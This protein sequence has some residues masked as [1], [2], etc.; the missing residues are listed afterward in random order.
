MRKLNLFLIVATLLLSSC[1]VNWH[2]STFNYDPIYEDENYIVVSD[3]IKVD[4]ISSRWD[5]E[6]KLRTD[7]SSLHFDCFPA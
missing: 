1:G 3:D 6:R 2:V 5:F 4:T 7:S